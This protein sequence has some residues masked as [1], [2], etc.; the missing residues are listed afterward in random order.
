M[1]LHASMISSRILFIYLLLVCVWVNTCAAQD[2]GW[3]SQFIEWDG[4]L[5][6]SGY[7]F[8]EVRSYP[9]DDQGNVIRVGIRYYTFGIPFT[10]LWNGESAYVF[11]RKGD[12]ENT[13][14]LD[15]YFS[16][17]DS[18]QKMATEELGHPARYIPWYHTA[19]FGW[20]FLVACAIIYILF[21]RWRRKSAIAH[22]TLSDADPSSSTE[23]PRPVQQT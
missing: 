7:R 13:R 16:L 4:H 2:S 18:E 3:R 20:P 10:P 17:S 14:S 11:L 19:L 8:V 12:E 6:S 23:S 1:S 9:V 15:G 22:V 5:I 21:K